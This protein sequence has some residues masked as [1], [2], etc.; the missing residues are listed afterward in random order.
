[1]RFEQR[2]HHRDVGDARGAVQRHLAAGEEGGRHDRQRGVLR[3]LDVDA[4]FEPCASDDAQGGIETIE[5]VHATLHPT[6]GSRARVSLSWTPPVKMACSCC[7]PSTAIW[8]VKARV[9]STSRIRARALSALPAYRP[10][11]TSTN[12]MLP[13]G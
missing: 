5:D 1:E 13:S 6:S 7:C 11:S 3:A 2:P 8:T 12:R 4:A 9:P 10:P